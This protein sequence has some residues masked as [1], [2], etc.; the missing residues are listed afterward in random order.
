MAPC[1]ASS[2][3]NQVMLLAPTRCPSRVTITSPF[4]AKSVPPAHRLSSRQHA[5]HA[6]SAPLRMRWRFVGADVRASEPRERTAVAAL[7]PAN[8]VSRAGGTGKRIASSSD[9]NRQCVQAIPQH[10]LDRVF[11]AGIHLEFRPEFVAANLVLVE[12][13]LQLAFTTIAELG[14]HA[15]DGILACPQ[16]TEFALGDIKFSAAMRALFVSMSSCGLG[17]LRRLLGSFE[18][19]ALALKLLVDGNQLGVLRAFRRSR[20]P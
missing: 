6:A 18:L 4:A 2:G 15:A 17:L 14:L 9:A 19:G 1:T 7:W 20:P 12:P 10:G 8:T 5:R 3:A 13:A 16:L 11:P